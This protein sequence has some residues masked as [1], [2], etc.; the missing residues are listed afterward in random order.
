MRQIKTRGYLIVVRGGFTPQIFHPSWFASK[1]LIGQKEADTAKVNIVHE[2]V[3]SFD[4][5][6]ANLQ[7]LADRF[8]VSTSDDGHEKAL[9]DFVIGTFK[10][11]MHT[12]ITAVGINQTVHFQVE[13]NETWHKI[14]HKLAPKEPIWNS[15]LTEPGTKSLIIEG[16]HS[17]ANKGYTLVK[18]EPSSHFPNSIY[19]E[20]NDHFKVGEDSKGN[21]AE[22]S[23]LLENVWEKSATNSNQIIENLIKN[24]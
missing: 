24:L 22:L 14:G 16:K 19:V 3:A 4:L 10:L 13:D 5:D 11:L 7:V 1:G 15:I 18:V 9:R 21:G 12:P 6:W 8:T 2:S 23:T 17:D 20:I